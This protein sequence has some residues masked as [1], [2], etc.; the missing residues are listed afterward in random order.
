[1]AIATPERVETTKAANLRLREETWS[2]LHYLAALEQR[3]KADIVEEA[4]R[5]Y[6]AEH[7]DRIASYM[8]EVARAAGLPSPKRVVAR[9]AQTA[10]SA[11][12]QARAAAAARGRRGSQQ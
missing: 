8:E 6:A 2:L 1:M 12:E 10:E 7:Q 3:A 4:L 9:H 5:D 11:L